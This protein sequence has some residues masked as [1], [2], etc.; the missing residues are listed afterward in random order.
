M[1]QTFRGAWMYLLSVC[2]LFG[3]RWWR[4]LPTADREERIGPSQHAAD[5]QDDEYRFLLCGKL[6][7]HG[8]GSLRIIVQKIGLAMKPCSGSTA[9]MVECVWG[10]MM[11]CDGLRV[12]WSAAGT[13]CWTDWWLVE[14]KVLPWRKCW[15]IRW[16]ELLNQLPLQLL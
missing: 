11:I 7:C 5:G 16:E 10:V 12:R 3:G 15:S 4:H 1:S 9:G 6:C 14:V 2:R 13:K 8:Y